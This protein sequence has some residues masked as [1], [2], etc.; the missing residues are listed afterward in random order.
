M[1][2]K[3][4]LVSKIPVDIR[5][6]HTGWDMINMPRADQPMLKGLRVDQE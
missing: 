3:D 2:K 5:R 1:I 4:W 6:K